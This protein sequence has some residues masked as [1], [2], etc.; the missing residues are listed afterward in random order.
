[1]TYP[2]M[3]QNADFAGYAL[4]SKLFSDEQA[5]TLINLEQRYEVWIEATRLLWRLPY[6]MR[7]KLIGDR[8]YLYEISDRQGNGHSLGRWTAEQASRL[9]EYRACKVA[10]RH[11]QRE[12]KAML[13]ASCAMARALRLPFLARTTGA[14]MR[15][16]D[17]RGLLG[18]RLIVLGVAAMA[19]YAGEAG[20]IFRNLSFETGTL[21]WHGLVMIYR[22]VCRP[23][24][25]Y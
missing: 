21:A 23:F 10:A 13:D 8:F 20:S 7:R 6:N 3:K 16:A 15:E 9:A 4:S 11:R 17:R 14:I 25:I 22:T 18:D 24:E 1:M 5:R 12:S 2:A 19:A